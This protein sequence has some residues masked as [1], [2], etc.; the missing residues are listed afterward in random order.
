MY[1]EK[2]IKYKQKYLNL[3]YEIYGNGTDISI[4]STYDEINSFL[5]KNNKIRC[6]LFLW[7]PRRYDEYSEYDKNI[8]Q[9]IY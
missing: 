1:K 6:I 2:Y 9:L 8:L 3:Y 5:T 7:D 4:S